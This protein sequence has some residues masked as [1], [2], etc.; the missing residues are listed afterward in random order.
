MILLDVKNM[1]VVH[2]MRA[3]VATKVVY[4]RV[5][6]AARCWNSR[7]RFLPRDGRLD[8]GKRAR[9]QI[10]DV[11]ELSVL[12]WLSTKDVNLFLKSYRWVLKTADWCNS[13]RGNGPRP[14][15]RR[16]VEDEKIIKPVF[17]I[18]T[19]EYKHHILDYAGRMELAHGRLTSNNRRYIKRQLLNSLLQIYKYHIREHLEPI[20]AAVDNNLW[21]VPQLAWVP[22]PRLRQLVF[23]NFWLK[24]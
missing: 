18:T 8:P 14:F 11:I 5:Y 23:V 6:E 15:K 12:V 9:V 7:R 16:Q 17:S 13:L 24:P 22:H 4:F 19:A 1:N 3:I 10:E 2:P 21:P 20:P